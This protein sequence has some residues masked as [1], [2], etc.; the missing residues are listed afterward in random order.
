MASMQTTLRENEIF[1]R[2]NVT[3]Q[4][5]KDRIKASTDTIRMTRRFAFI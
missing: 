2:D 4:T 1:E 3:V 5:R